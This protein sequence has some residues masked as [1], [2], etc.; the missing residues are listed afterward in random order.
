MK[1]MICK[2][3][4][5]TINNKFYEAKEMMFGLREKFDYFQCS[6]CDC[7][8]ILAFPQDMS[9]Y[10]PSNYYSFS[11]VISNSP[12]KKFIINQRNKFAIFNKGLLGK[13]LYNYYPNETYKLLSATVIDKSNKVL[14][15]GCGDGRFISALKDIGFDN[16]LG[17]DPFIDKDIQ[18]DNGLKIVKKSIHE[19][20]GKWDF[21]MFHHSFEHIPDPTET[22]GSVAKL[23]TD[24]GTCL[25][26][27]PTVSSY[28]WEHY[29]ENWVQ[30]DAPRHFFLHSVKS[31]ELLAA[32][33]NLKIE[34]IIYDSTEFQFWGSEQYLKDV[35]LFDNKSYAVN[36][37]AS[38]F[39]DV[40]I[41]VFKKR[42]VEL[43][44]A[45]QGDAAAFFITKK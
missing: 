15:M 40:E 43:N 12:I 28:A 2:V 19:M 24:S 11:T 35:P 26:R 6:N 17:A 38:I 18:H 30:F 33:A 8:Q 14:D 31:M 3:C 37:K 22:L 4:N 29:R 20:D 44:A 1:N 10:Y 9:K 45:N 23:L 39:S 21:I 16:V 25:I 7:L 41:G 32:K 13:L 5:N 27:I 36:P 34:K 42:S